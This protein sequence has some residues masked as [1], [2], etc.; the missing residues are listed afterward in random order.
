MVSSRLVL[1]GSEHDIVERRSE[2]E[3]RHQNTHSKSKRRFTFQFSLDLLGLRIKFH[4]R[5]VRLG[6]PYFFP[7]C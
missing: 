5:N 6:P 2:E 7:E 3:G 4:R 1:C